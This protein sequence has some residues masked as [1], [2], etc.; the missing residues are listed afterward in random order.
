MEW[1]NPTV[2]DAT[3][4]APWVSNSW[5]E[6]RAPEPIIRPDFADNEELKKAYGVA[7]GQGLDAFNAAMEV[8]NQELP[9]ALWASLNWIKDPI[10]IGAKDAY[11]KTLKQAEKPLDKEEL[12]AEVLETARLAG[13]FKDK[14]ALLKLYSEIAGFTGKIAIDA[15]T[16]TN[17][18]TQ[19]NTTQIV[20]V[21]GRDEPPKATASSDNSKSKIYNNMLPAL[22]LVGGSV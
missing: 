18:N 17:N 8:F 12:L 11:L 13:E 3:N 2:F 4:T 10:V 7:L 14:A 1:S 21:K 16:V 15:S 5:T 22:K 9:K 20:L 19:N 6:Q